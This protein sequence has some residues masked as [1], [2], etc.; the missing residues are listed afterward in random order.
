VS[1]IFE[2]GCKALDNKALTDGFAMTSDQT[3]IFVETFHHPAMTMGWNQ[4][5]R[6]ITTFN[7]SAG[8]Q[9]D[10]IKSYSQI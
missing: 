9:V 10:I 7:N 3:V 5:A 6:Q 4:G 8:R 1:A 2:Q